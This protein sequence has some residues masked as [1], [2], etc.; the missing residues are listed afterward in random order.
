MKV[1][2][3]ISGLKEMPPTN[4]MAFTNGTGTIFEPVAAPYLEDDDGQC[5]LDLVPIKRSITVNSVAADRADDLGPVAEVDLKA[6]LDEMSTWLL[7]GGMELERTPEFVRLRE[8][9][10]L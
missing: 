8:L 9:L 6:L 2:H 5:W 3:L 1:A 4:D 7:Y 10:N